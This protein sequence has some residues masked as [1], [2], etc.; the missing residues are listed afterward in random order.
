MLLGTVVQVTLDAAAGDRD[1]C[2]H[3][4]PLPVGDDPAA[5][6]WDGTWRPA[7]WEHRR[8][9]GYTIEID[10]PTTYFSHGAEALDL[11]VR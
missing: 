5:A 7:H 3:R 8:E 4:W 6:P 10:S 9:F 1:G 2:H 11:R